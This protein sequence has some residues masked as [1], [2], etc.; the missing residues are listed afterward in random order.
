MLFRSEAHLKEMALK[1]AGPEI[2]DRVIFTDVAQKDDHIHRGRIAD[3]FLDTTEVH[4][5]TRSL[6]GESLMP[7]CS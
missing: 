7:R 5:V 4:S 1:W 3:L 6:F 2:A